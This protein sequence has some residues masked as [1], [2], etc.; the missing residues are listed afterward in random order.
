MVEVGGRVWDECISSE[1]IAKSDLSAGISNARTELK[2]NEGET[3]PRKASVPKLEHGLSGARSSPALSGFGVV[4]S[5]TGCEV[6]G[7]LSKCA[8]AVHTQGTVQ[9]VQQK[10]GDSAL[11]SRTELEQKQNEAQPQAQKKRTKAVD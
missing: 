11:V 8:L 2:M 7:N 1:T 3:R 9:L 4:V 6:V 5:G 10:E